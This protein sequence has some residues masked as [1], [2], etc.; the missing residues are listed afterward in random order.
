M[1]GVI[2]RVG[3]EQTIPGDILTC[4]WLEGVIIVALLLTTPVLWD[5]G[6][7]TVVFARVLIGLNNIAIVQ[8]YL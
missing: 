6:D 3:A 8:T 5:C 7:A 4:G 2:V 1:Y